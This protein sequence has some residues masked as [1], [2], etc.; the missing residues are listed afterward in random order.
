MKFENL[1][2]LIDCQPRYWEDSMI[3]GEYD[4]SFCDTKGV[5]KPKM[6][7][8]EQIKDEPTDVIYSNH[9]VWRPIIDYNTGK[10]ENWTQGVKANVCYKICD[11]FSCIFMNN[12]I[13]IKEYDGYV[14]QFLSI[15]DEGYGDYAI[16]TI[17]E[18]GTIVNWDKVKHTV[19]EYI[20]YEHD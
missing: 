9:W 12:D 2:I 14:P 8:A 3:N 18:D 19:I 1:K 20:E 13:I 17:L 4:I 15:D 10:I 16:F 6:P 7:C 11:N 5:G